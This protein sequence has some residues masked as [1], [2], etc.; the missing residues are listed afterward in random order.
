MQKNVIFSC[1]LVYIVAYTSVI[2]ASHFE[3]GTITYKVLNTSGSIV[4]IVVTQTY[5][6]DYTKITC[7]NSMIAN[8][9]PALTF[10]PPYME[11]SKTVDCIQYCNQSGGYQPPGVVSYCTDYSVGLGITVGQRSDTINITNGS[12]FLI[13]YQSS[14]W[15]QLSLPSGTSNT[16]WSIS[17][18]INLKMRSNG[19]YNNPPVATIISPIYIP[20]HIQQ[21]IF[22][23]TIDA[24]NDPV[25]C[26]FANGTNEC[27]QVCPPA[28]LPS[29]TM[30]L[31]NCTLIITGANVNDWYAVA[32]EVSEMQC[33]YS[34]HFISIEY[35][36]L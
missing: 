7:T 28:S 27:G 1:F 25:R 17:C 15:R 14:S 30:I 12:Y 26:R 23:P 18:L 29:G 11:N 34:L 2:N 36:L 22:I 19:S 20:V 21:S 32:I 4:S 8:Q 6:Y 24:D 13:A 5:I 3:G 16:D 33:Y 31:S 35:L 9:S 10:N